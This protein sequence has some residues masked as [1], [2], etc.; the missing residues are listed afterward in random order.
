MRSSEKIIPIHILAL[1]VLVFAGIISYKFVRAWMH[2]RQPVG[3]IYARDT[4]HFAISLRRIFNNAKAA[5]Y[6]LLKSIVKR[7]YG[8]FTLILKINHALFN[9]FCSVVYETFKITGFFFNSALQSIHRTR[10]IIARKYYLLLHP[11]L[12]SPP[13][14]IPVHLKLKAIRAKTQ[15]VDS[16]I[17]KLFD[18]VQKQSPRHI[19][20][21]RRFTFV[22]IIKILSAFSISLN[23]KINTAKQ[24]KVLRRALKQVHP[25]AAL[26]EQLKKRIQNVDLRSAGVAR[27]LKHLAGTVQ[28]KKFD[29]PL[30]PASEVKELLKPAPDADAFLAQRLRTVKSAACKLQ[31]QL[32]AVEPA[33]APS[34]ASPVRP[35]LDAQTITA[36]IARLERG[37][38]HA[39]QTFKQLDL[40][41]TSV[42]EAKKI[43]TPHAPV[44]SS[45]SRISDRLSKIEHNVKE[46]NKEFEALKRDL[47]LAP[48]HIQLSVPPAPKPLPSIPSHDL[49]EPPHTPKAKDPE[50][51]VN[52][53]A[54]IARQSGEFEQQLEDIKEGITIKYSPAQPKLSEEEV[55]KRLETIR[56]DSAGMQKELNQM[57]QQANKIPEQIEED[58]NLLQ[59]EIHEVKAMLKD[60]KARLK[61]GK[62]KNDFE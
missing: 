59:Q 49:P 39:E 13:S 23:K 31:S 20:Q 53:I 54:K 14:A 25:L 10:K 7:S 6:E 50:L 21:A 41:H 4:H 37:A 42:E 11:P 30:R 3:R 28:L 38:I 34:C 40:P 47:P 24:H 55:K 12:A 58:S 1:V 46:A 15:Y 43:L 60:H 26:P 56:E 16:Q 33:L 19:V 57:K 18:L 27:Q 32:A 62:E 8:F 52:S 22:P 5:V 51:I 61:M 17:K 2:R 35:V 48:L 45:P 29:R 44:T 36:R 9:S